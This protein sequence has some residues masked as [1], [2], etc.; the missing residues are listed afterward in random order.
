MLSITEQFFIK[1]KTPVPTEEQERGTD[2]QSVITNNMYIWS[3]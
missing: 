3:E 1:V 2:Q